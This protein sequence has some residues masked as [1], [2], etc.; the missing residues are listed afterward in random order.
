MSKMPMEMPALVA[1][2][3]PRS[4]SRS[5]VST[6]PCWPDELV[7][8]EDD[9]GELLLAGHL[10]EEAHALRPDL[11]EAHA[12]GGRLDDLLFGVAE[13]RLLAEV[14]V[15]EPDAVVRLD[16]AFVDGEIDF[17]RVGEQRQALVAI[18]LRAADDARV[19]RDVVAA[20]R[21]VLRRGGD[22]L[23][24]RRREDVVRRQHQHAGFHLRFDGQRD[25]HG[26]LVTVEVRVVGGA[27]ERVNADGL[28]LDQ[29]RLESLDRQTVQGG[30]A[31]QE[32][33][34]ALGHFLEDVPDLR[35]LALDHLLG[36]ADGVDVAHLLQAG[37]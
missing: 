26:H 25:V 29:H 15:L 36:R 20:Q 4:L 7:G 2:V 24:A 17:R 30:G 12:A 32:H 21:D 13:E 14:R 22:R 33:R 10:V 9:V 5:S 35:R 27:N 3:K 8:L 23:A 28:A 34:V 16:G 6:V 31:V 37:G 19:L 1:S 11:V 18:G